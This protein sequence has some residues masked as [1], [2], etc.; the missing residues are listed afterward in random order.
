MFPVKSKKT[1][2]ASLWIAVAMGVLPVTDPG[3]PFA[4][5]ALAGCTK[6]VAY[7][8]A[9]IGSQQG[10]RQRW[11]TRALSATDWASGGFASEV[12]WVGTDD[13]QADKDWVEVGATKGWHG[14]NVY[15]LYTAHG[16]SSLGIYDENDF[17]AAPALGTA[18]MFTVRNFN[19]TVP[20]SYIAEVSW[21]ASSYASMVWTGHGAGTVDFS[22]G[23]EATCHTSRIDRTH[24]SVNQFR[25]NGGTWISPSVG[26]LVNTGPP[27]AIA[28][29]IR[30]ISFRYWQNSGIPTNV[31]S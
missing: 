31:C 29:C 11:I 6:H 27:S 19:A 16:R 21:G 8:D 14:A 2:L 12:L 1:G 30:P 22:G 4:G 7:Q 10:A 24:V 17:G 3:L 18:V 26:D 5:T 13:G 28:W 20:N 25:S 23:L 9:Q 15:R